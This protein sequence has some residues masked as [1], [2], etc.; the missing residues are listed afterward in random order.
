MA[1]YTQPRWRGLL[2][3]ATTMLLAFGWATACGSGG[4]GG[5]NGSP[6]AGL[7][8]GRQRRGRPRAGF[9]H[10]TGRHVLQAEQPH[11]GKRRRGQPPPAQRKPHRP[12]LYAGGG[13]QPQRSAGRDRRRLLHGASGGNLLHYFYCDV[14]GHAAAGMV[15]R[16]VI[17]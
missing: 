17:R 3:G 12:Q 7:A 6:R 10:R 5:T 15:G 16:L 1:V 14:P 9:A 4:A 8:S 2:A 11:G 13:D